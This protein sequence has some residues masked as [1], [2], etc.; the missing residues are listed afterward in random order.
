MKSEKQV[1][2]NTNNVLGFSLSPSASW[3]AVW[4]GAYFLSIN[5]YILGSGSGSSNELSQ[6]CEL[7][8][9]L[10][11]CLLVYLDADGMAM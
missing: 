6:S 10:S 8:V 1:D 4:L 2:M 11:D 7:H 5:L 3:L 9:C